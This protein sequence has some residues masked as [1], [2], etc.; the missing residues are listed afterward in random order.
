[1]G[2]AQGAISAVRLPNEYVI[3]VLIDLVLTKPFSRGVG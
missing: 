3:I 1:M 2:L